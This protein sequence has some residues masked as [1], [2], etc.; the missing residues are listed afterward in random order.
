ME[1]IQNTNGGLT[2]ERKRDIFFYFDGNVDVDVEWLVNL[3][4][5]KGSSSNLIASIFSLNMRQ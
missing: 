2:L 1:V 5:G 3:F 4:V